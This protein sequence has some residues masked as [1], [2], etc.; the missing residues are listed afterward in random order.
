MTLVNFKKAC[1]D[2]GRQRTERE[3]SMT[4]LY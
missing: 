3:Q 2:S 4:T 1:Y